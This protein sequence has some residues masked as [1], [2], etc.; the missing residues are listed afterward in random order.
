[1]AVR[2]VGLCGPAARHGQRH[3][4]SFT[5]RLITSSVS[6]L[7]SG[8]RV[9]SLSG[10]SGGPSSAVIESLL[11][12]FNANRSQPTKRGAAF[13]RPYVFADRCRAQKLV[14][15]RPGKYD[16]TRRAQVPRRSFDKLAAGETS[17]R[18]GEVLG[19]AGGAVAN[20][21]NR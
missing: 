3:F 14:M 2:P 10:P 8:G 11:V 4:V 7:R 15:Q 6:G 21:C 13:E 17:P 1:V 18:R 16:V 9:A 20:D 19:P 12:K 5:I